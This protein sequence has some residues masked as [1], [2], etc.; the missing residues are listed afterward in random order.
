METPKAMRASTLVLCLALSACTQFP[1]LDGAVAPDV[2][3]ADFPALVP[4]EP[5]LASAAP[6][7]DDPVAASRALDARVAALRARARA[8]QRRSI[9]DSGSRSRL[10]SATN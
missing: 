1:E 4:L 2:E 3:D 9:V 8:L 5:L 6:I 10:T 7:V